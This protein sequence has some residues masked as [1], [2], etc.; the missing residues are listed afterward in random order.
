[1]VQHG[2]SVSSEQRH[3]IRQLSTLF[4]RDDGECA[5]AGRLPVDG[6]V[7]G[8]TFHQVRVPCVLA[9]AQV[10]VACLALAGLS[11]DMS[12]WSRGQDGIVGARASMGLGGQAYGTC[13]HERIDPTL[14][15]R[16]EASLV[17]LY[18]WI[19]RSKR[20]GGVAATVVIIVCRVCKQATGRGSKQCGCPDQVG[21]ATSCALPCGPDES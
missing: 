6:Q 20:R 18:N 19:C 9:D 15:H 4:Q 1:V 13:S 10:V 5:A 14:L 21:T 8:V 3:N 16:M 11:K 7:L 12:W 17:Y 2:S